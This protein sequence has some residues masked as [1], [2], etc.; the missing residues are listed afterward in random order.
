MKSVTIPNS[1]T[2]IGKNAFDYCSGLTSIEIPNSVTSIGEF[3]FW[4]C[5][6]LISIEIPNSV[7]SI[8]NWTFWGC[9][10]LT[11]VTIPNSITSIGNG[12]FWSCTSL[13]SIEIPNS[14]TSIG[15][16]AFRN[17]DSL[18]SLIIGD[19]SYKNQVIKDDKC[20]AYKA[21]NANMTCK[22]FQYEEG[23]T[24]EL[25]D[26]PILCHYGFHACLNLADVFNYYKGT[27]KRDIVV[28]EVELEDVSDK[29]REDSKVVAKKITIGK[30]IL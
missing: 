30:R 16:V 20:K 26:E 9:T 18:T 27:F 2:S 22:D 6:N 8:E 3:A 7:I 24:Y 17:C 14:V 19:K 10:G 12:A 1:V 21:F 25:D 4:G 23:K 5:T 29:R 13:I 15:A 11:S 28:H